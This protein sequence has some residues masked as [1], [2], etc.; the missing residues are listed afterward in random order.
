M[1]LQRMRS[2]HLPSLERW[3]ASLKG[4][5]KVKEAWELCQHLCLA[6]TGAT[7][8]QA[9]AHLYAQLNHLPVRHTFPCSCVCKSSSFLSY[10]LKSLL[11]GQS[12]M[13]G[14]CCCSID[15]LYNQHVENSFVLFWRVFLLN[16]SCIPLL[17]VLCVCSEQYKAK[18]T[19]MLKIVKDL[20]EEI[21]QSSIF[22]L[23]F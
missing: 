9:T 4:H 7:T 3:A 18:G 2:L 21:L 20:H 6:H 1:F 5:K 8:E 13:W 16:I 10:K 19:C 23:H 14:F 15:F 12:K 11:H 17:L 22:T